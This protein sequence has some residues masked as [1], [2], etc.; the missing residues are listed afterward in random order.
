MASENT[1]QD[2]FKVADD[3]AHRTVRVAA[4]AKLKEEAR[5]A[6]DAYKT[7]DKALRDAFDSDDADFDDFD[8][9]AD[10][11][12][13]AVMLGMYA[14]FLNLVATASKLFGVYTLARIRA[15]EAE[16]WANE[17]IHF[18]ALGIS[19]GPDA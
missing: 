13:P 6:F 17:P 8:D 12:N 7:A 19:G 5:T 3:E 11:D 9:D 15:G 10:F 4:A 14:S 18:D 16:R 1:E 2:P